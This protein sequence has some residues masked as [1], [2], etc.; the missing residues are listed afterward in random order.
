M[1]EYNTTTKEDNPAFEEWDA[2]DREK[3][4]IRIDALL[5]EFSRDYKLPYSFPNND[6]PYM[7]QLP[8]FAFTVCTRAA[9]FGNYNAGMSLIDIEKDLARCFMY[10]QKRLIEL[11]EKNYSTYCERSYKYQERL[12]EEQE[13]RDWQEFKAEYDKNERRRKEREEKEAREIEA[14]MREWDAEREEEM[15]EIREQYREEESRRRADEEEDRYWKEKQ[16]KEA[17]QYLAVL[18]EPMVGSLAFFQKYPWLQNT[19]EY[20]YENWKHLQAETKIF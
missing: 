13:E 10:I 5:K 12:R 1:S 8:A 2:A 16:R 3:T 7:N 11:N 20:D 18:N 4:Q 6:V 15:E 14:S 17:Q 9:F 19:Y